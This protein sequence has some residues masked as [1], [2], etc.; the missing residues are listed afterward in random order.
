MQ[1]RK[2]AG[3]RNR[4]RGG[5]NPNKTWGKDPWRLPFQ[6]CPAIHWR[7]NFG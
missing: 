7:K 3:M 1:P 5:D 6:Q 4:H 2:N